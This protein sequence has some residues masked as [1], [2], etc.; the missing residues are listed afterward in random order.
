[1]RRIAALA[2]VPTTALVL[3]ACG[4]TT[5]D[6][7]DAGPAPTLTATSGEAT[8]TGDATDGSATDDTSST[9]DSGSQNTDVG[10]AAGTE[11]ASFG[12]PA[13]VGGPYGE[14]R[15]GVWAIG[16]AGEVEFRVTGPNSLELI[17]AVAN[18]GWDITEQEVESDS[19]EVDFRRDNVTF[20]F[21]VEMSNGVLEI[22]IDQ[23]IDRAEN[24]TFF[25]GEAGT[26]A[27]SVD[28]SRLVL[29][30]V[31]LMDGWNETSRDVDNDDV[32]LDFRRDGD[33]F[34]ELWEFNADLDDGKLEIEIDYEIE[35]RFSS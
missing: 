24:G 35:G 11:D 16:P 8:S 25:V 22:E 2:L 29:G 32:E 20:E 6:S 23:D 18:D 15:D 7:G 31:G 33:G 17:A 28:G 27:V 9:D 5:A 30:D 3:A 13:D 19:I 4:G 34:F 21:E 1:M 14:L 12:T 10:S 26:V